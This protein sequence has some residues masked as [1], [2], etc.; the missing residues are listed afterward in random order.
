MTR[1]RGGWWR[2][3][4]GAWTRLAHRIGEVQGRLLLTLLYGV[5]ILPFGLGV[6]L[7]ADPLRCRRP[8][9]SNWTP[10]AD[11]PPAMAEARRQ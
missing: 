3:A 2:G 7:L 1:D 11:P 6:R 5:L 8:A 10:R 9:G 4:W